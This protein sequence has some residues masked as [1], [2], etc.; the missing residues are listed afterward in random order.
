[1]YKLH[2]V[3]HTMNYLLVEMLSAGLLL[4]WTHLSGRRTNVG[5]SQGGPRHARRRKERQPLKMEGAAIQVWK[6]LEDGRCC[7]P[8]LEGAELGIKFREIR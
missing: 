2:D 7:T 4:L 5:P 1:L 3:Y 8:R 6:A